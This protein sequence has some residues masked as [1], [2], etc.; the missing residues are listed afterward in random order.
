MEFDLFKGIDREI[1]KNA[2]EAASKT[3][4]PDESTDNTKTKLKK[5]YGAGIEVTLSPGST[6]RKK[7]TIQRGQVEITSRA[8]KYDKGNMTL[9]VSC[10]RKWA[11]QD[12]IE[13]QRYALVACISHSDPKV[14]LYNRMKIQIEQRERIRGRV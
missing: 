13:I 14:D 8:K 1:V 2:Y 10:N 12:E 9:V 11:K 4:F 5:K 7:G 3:S 6:V